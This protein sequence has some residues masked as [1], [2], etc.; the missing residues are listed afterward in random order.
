MLNEF[1]FIRPEWFILL[2][3]LCLLVIAIIKL[4]KLQSCW[5]H[6]IAPHLMAK[7]MPAFNQGKNQHPIVFSVA[8]VLTL[9]IIA[10][11]GPT[12]EKLPQ[13][14]FDVQQGHV[15]LM[16]MSLSMRA[17]DVTPD[18]LTRA[19]FKA[20]DLLKT[21]NEG[22]MGLVAYAGDAFTISPLTTDIKTLN[23]LIPSLSPEIMPVAGSDALSG[24]EQAAELLTQA[25]YPSGTI[26]WI[27]DGIEPS[28][29]RPIRKWLSDHSLTVHI[30]AVGTDEGAPIKQ[31]SGEL[32]KD[33]SGS[34]VIPKLEVTRLSPL[35]RQTRGVLATMTADDSDITLLTSQGLQ[36]QAEMSEEVKNTLAGDEWHELGPYLVIAALPFALYLFR[37]GIVVMVFMSFGVGIMTPPPAAAQTPLSKW[38][39]NSD[40]QGLEQYNKKAF[41]QAATNFD[42]LHWKGAAQYRNGD[43]EAAVETF[44]QLD[45]ADAWYN[46]GNALAQMQDFDSAMAAYEQAIARQ[47]DHQQALQNKALLEQ[48][49]DQQQQDKNQG[50]QQQDDQQQE[51]QQQQ[52]QQN[53]SQQNNADQQQEQQQDQPSEPQNNE[54]DQEQQNQQVQQQAD[55]SEQQSEQQNSQTEEDQGDE[56]QAEENSQQQTE[57]QPQSDEQKQAQVQQAPQPLTDEEREQQQKMEALLRR[58]PNDPAFLLQRKMQ[59]EAQQRKRMRLPANQEKV[60]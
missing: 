15:V 30:L 17:T 20:I 56:N 57:E 10:L 14:V 5:Q 49:K 47:P 9:G 37:K 43:Y 27:T 38:F 58:I 1:H 2:L 48:L 12:Y 44:S 7:M 22:E 13:P 45:S 46:K 18:R 33:S 51:N 39:K 41:E 16:D 31:T 29:A 19:K 8:A 52:D 35:A 32:L 11:A 42:D 53:E 26:Y 6:I 3:P 23:T 25:G 55:Q 59:L 4:P 60:W 50:N 24:L 54:P 40:Q 21:I 36:Q 34:I 28:D